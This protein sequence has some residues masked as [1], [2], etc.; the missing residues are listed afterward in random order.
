MSS[1][2]AWVMTLPRAEAELVLLKRDPYPRGDFL[3]L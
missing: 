3:G 2:L 1:I